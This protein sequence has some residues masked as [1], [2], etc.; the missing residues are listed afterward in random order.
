M[1]FLLNNERIVAEFVELCALKISG[2]IGISP[3]MINASVE[4]CD[5][6]VKPSFGVPKNVSNPEEVTRIISSTWRSL[7][8]TLISRLNYARQK[9]P[10]IA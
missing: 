8:S 10:D 2:K 5:G 6:K 9:R 3:D 1:V 7:K 4:L